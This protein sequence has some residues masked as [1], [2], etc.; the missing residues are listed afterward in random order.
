VAGEIAI[1][2]ILAAIALGFWFTRHAKGANRP[3]GSIAAES[4]QSEEVRR[5]GRGV[6]FE[7]GPPA[8]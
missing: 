2:G 4:F 7:D 3:P 6:G 5:L 8:D 1:V